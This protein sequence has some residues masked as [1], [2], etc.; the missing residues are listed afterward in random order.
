MSLP[1]RNN[2]YSFKEFLDWREQ[3]DYYADDEVLQKIVKFYAGADFDQVDKAVRETSKK[4]SKRWRKFSDAIGRCEE[5]PYLIHY[6]GANNR[7]DRIVRPYN[8]HVLEQEIFSEALFSQDTDFWTMVTK[9]FVIHQ[10]GD[11]CIIC[12]LA[13][14][15][16]VIEAIRQ[17][18]AISPEVERILQHCAE[19]IDGEFAIGA[20]F[21]S[22]IQGGSDIP[23][24]LLEAVNENGTWRLY[25]TKFFCSATHADY[26]MITAKPQD[27]E[28]VGLFVIPMWLPGDKDKEIRN[29]YTIDQL[30]YKMG[31]CELTTGEITFNGALAYP[32]GPLNRGVANMVGIILTLSRLDVALSAGAYMKRAAREARKYAGFREAFDSKVDQ[33]PMIVWQLD[34]LD[35]YANRTIAGAFRLYR[36]FQKMEGGLKGGLVEDESLEARKI[37]FAVRELVMMQKM[38][39]TWDATDV[40]RS[41]M[42]IFGGYGVM[43]DFSSLPRLYR[44][45]AVN[46]LWEG[47][48]N[49]LLDQVYRDLKRA[50]KWYNPA[51]F[52]KDILKGFDAQ[53]VDALAQEMVEILTYPEYGTLSAESVKMAERWH[54]FVQ[55]FMYAYQDLAILEVQNS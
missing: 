36:D 2:P 22:E 42:S 47:P 13:C 18:G 5:R 50:S 38:A 25:G 49:V 9:Q 20:Q 34:K 29:G 7:I 10:N 35:K 6:D 12:P 21:I 30:K 43:E 8:T 52:V 53:V 11:A 26:C 39:T 55:K 45:A 41:A 31:T 23:A 4:A 14:T 32:V 15:H 17:L 19:G 51:D 1:N 28:E 48:R 16:G 44:D 24:N 54:E 3:V 37:R 27:S 40:L 33:F 46:E